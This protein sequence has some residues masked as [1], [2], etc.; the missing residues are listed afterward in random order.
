MYV[1]S[2]TFTSSSSVQ[3]E[4]LAKTGLLYQ[5]AEVRSDRPAPEVVSNMQMGLCFEELIRKFAEISNETAGEH[6]TRAKVIRLM[7]N[8]IFGRRRGA[9]RW[10]G[11]VRTLYDHTAGTQAACSAWPVIPGRAEPRPGTVYGR[12]LN[13][14]RTPSVRPTCSSR[15][16][17]GQHRLWEHPERRRPPTRSSTTCWPTRPLA[18][19]GRRSKGMRKEPSNAVLTGALAPACRA[20]QTAPCRSCCT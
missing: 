3:I 10:P 4:R 19:N 7:V 15:A 5:V 9:H 20:C 17:R 2:L 6:F 11:V 12:E 13:S 18:W 8:L 16:G 1:T 14:S